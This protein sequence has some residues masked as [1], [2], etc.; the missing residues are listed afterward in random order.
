MKL[1]S[2]NIRIL[3]MFVEKGVK[4]YVYAVPLTAEKSTYRLAL[5]SQHCRKIKRTDM[6]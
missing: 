5:A 4:I 2:N 6:T 3:M 1:Y